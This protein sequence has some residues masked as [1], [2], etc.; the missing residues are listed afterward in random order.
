M[1][2]EKPTSG[3]DVL[4]VGFGTGSRRITEAFADR[5]VRF[6]V[7]EKDRAMASQARAEGHA[8]IEGDATEPDIL[9]KARVDGVDLVAIPTEQLDEA[10]VKA[11]RRSRPVGLILTNLSLGFSDPEP[12]V[13]AR[14]IGRMAKVIDRSAS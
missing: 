2:Q 6:V 11:I 14:M 12:D 10:V 1:Q 5:Q 13:M 3:L 7:V 8:V 4:L 9:R